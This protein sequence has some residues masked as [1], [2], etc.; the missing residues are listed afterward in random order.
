M[1]GYLVIGFLL[2]YLERG[3]YVPFVIWRVGVGLLLIVGLAT[4][5]LTA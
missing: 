5:V 3:T 1:V 4:G 2:K